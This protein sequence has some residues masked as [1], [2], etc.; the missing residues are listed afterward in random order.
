MSYPTGVAP[1]KIKS[2]KNAHEN[3]HQPLDENQSFE[4]FLTDPSWKNLSAME[5]YNKC[6]ENIQWIIKQA[7][8]KD[9]SI[10]AMGSGWSLSKVAVSEDALINTM[11]LRHRFTLGNDYFLPEFLAEHQADNYRFVQCGNTIIQ[12][13]ESLE[14]DA[15]PPKAIRSSG[16]SN[17]QTIVGAF[18]TNTHGASIDYGAISE[19]VKGLHIVTGPNQHYYLER[20]SE[21]VTSAKFHQAIKAT[22]VQDDHLFNAALISFGSFGVI[23]GVLL[24]VEDKY[25]LEQKMRRVVYDDKLERAILYKQYELI[26]EYLKYP[27]ADTEHPLYHFELALNP[28]DFEFG[29]PEKGVYLRVM[30]KVPY[31]DNYQRI[32][33]AANGYTYGDDV[34]GLIQT[35]LNMTESMA[36]FLNRK[37]I[38]ELV[39]TLFKTAY[40]RPDDAVGTVGETFKN[41]VF[42][43]KLFSAAF[44]LDRKDVRKVI[45][46]CLRINRKTRLAGVL[47]FRFVKGTQATLGFTR[48]PDTCV[49]ELDGADAKVNH[50]FVKELV[51]DL[52][53]HDIP[54]ALHWGKINR[55]LDAARL[56]RI[57]GSERIMDWKQ[58]RSRIMTEDVQAV[59]NNEFMEGVGL[60]EYVPLEEPVMTV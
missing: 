34:L 11:M 60:D 46:I 23:H 44:G 28:H 5:Q 41:T 37:M 25:L 39:N 20:A 3:F 51:R 31:Y 58:Q 57:Y 14:Q 52:E 36:G 35:V 29:N 50:K 2:F 15:N 56:R 32:D 48:W 9:L 10:R 7:L 21:K 47:A 26:D 45:D 42:R 8:D 27:M 33:H 4:L 38:P 55:I 22:V 54:F 17:G 16:G 53:A 1:W 6:T 24:E 13:N 40:E 18:S 19:M 59:F 30:H 12:L 49:L 43:G